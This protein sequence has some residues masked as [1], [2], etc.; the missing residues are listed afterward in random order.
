MTRTQPSNNSRGGAILA[1][2]RLREL[3]K[4]DDHIIVSPGVYDGLTARIALRDGF[5]CLYMVQPS[6]LGRVS[7]ALRLIFL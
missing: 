6:L 3:L 4:R 2:S 7:T 1:V 5:E